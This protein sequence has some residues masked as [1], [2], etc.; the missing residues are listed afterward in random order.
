M[1]FANA[2][3]QEATTAAATTAVAAE[4][5]PFASMLPLILIFVVFYFLL[6][7]PQ[8]KKFKEHKAMIDSVKKG[9]KVLTGGGIYGVVSHVESDGELQ[10]EIAS[11][12]NVKVARSTL[13]SIF[14][15]DGTVKTPEKAATKPVAN[16]NKN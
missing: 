14:N 9:D 8:Q 2:F 15:A 10:V 3:A 6:I 12:V 13:A 1:L 16:D 4:G 7:R 11:G 5:S